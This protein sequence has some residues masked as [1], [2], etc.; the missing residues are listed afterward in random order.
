MD[1]VRQMMAKTNMVFRGL[2]YMVAENY[3]IESKNKY[4]YYN[5]SIG[6]L[7]N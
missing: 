5:L 2:K 6:V 7:Y 4:V 3:I 1:N